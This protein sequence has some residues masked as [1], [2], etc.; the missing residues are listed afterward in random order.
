MTDID[1][2][3]QELAVADGWHAVCRCAEDLNQL[4]AAWPHLEQ[5]QAIARF[6][7]GLRERGSFRHER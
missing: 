7:D 3:L 1:R 5:E 2:I 4:T 6:N